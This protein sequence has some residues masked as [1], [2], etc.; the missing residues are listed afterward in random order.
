MRKRIP[1]ELI[2]MFLVFISC[3]SG[4]TAIKSSN[5]KKIDS[6]F[7]GTFKNLS[8]KNTR[9]HNS[10]SELDNLRILK[11]FKIDNKNVDSINLSFTTDNSLVIEYSDST[12][13]RT[14]KFNGEFS[15]R[16]FYEIYFRKQNI[17]I[18]P[19]F[20]IIYSKTN[21]DRIRISLSTEN[22]L[23]IDH[24]IAIGGNILILAGGGGSNSIYYFERIK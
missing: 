20:P 15:K 1:F 11:L 10:S 22:E 23:L 16:G 18:P 9:K 24:Y 2:P 8:Y 6:N 21:I 19:L 5:F 7:S 17:E 12:G 3:G 4:M 14:E 13:I